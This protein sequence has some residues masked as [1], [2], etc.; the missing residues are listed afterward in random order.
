MT[1]FYSGAAIATHTRGT[2]AVRRQAQALVDRSPLSA[3]DAAGRLLTSF[4]KRRFY[5]VYPGQAHL[6]WAFKRHAPELYRRLVPPVFDYLDRR[7]SKR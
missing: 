4:A 1:T 5:A 3:D 6:L 2:D 7:L